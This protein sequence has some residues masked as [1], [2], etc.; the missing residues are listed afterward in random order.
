M[1]LA[2]PASIG[3]AG[4]I[5]AH[6]VWFGV[7]MAGGVSNLYWRPVAG[8]RAVSERPQL[9]P[10]RGLC[11]RS[12]ALVDEVAVGSLGQAHRQPGKRVEGGS[13]VPPP[14]PAEDEFVE[15][16]L[17]VGFAQA[18]EGAQTPALQVGEHPVHP[19]QQDM[20]GHAADHLA[21]VLVFLEAEIGRQ[22]VADDRGAG[23]DDTTD[24]PGDAGRREVVQAVEPDAPRLALVRQLDRADH[25]QLANVAAALA[26]GRRICLGPVGEV[27]LVHLD[28]IDQRGAIGV[29]HGAAQLM[30]QQPG[31]L[32]AAQPELG[33]KLQ[34]RDPVRMAAE[35]MDC[36][37]PQGQRQ[38]AA[39][40]RC[41]GR[42]RGLPAAPG[43]F[44]GEPLGGQLPA[45]CP[46]AG[47]A[48]KALR[49]ALLEQVASAGRIIGKSLRQLGT[50]HRTVMFPAA[51]H[52]NII[53]TSAPSRQ[54][55]LSAL[56]TTP[57]STGTKGISHKIIVERRDLLSF[58]PDSD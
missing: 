17:Q 1:V 40:H 15:I 56:D 8:G 4:R 54:L 27:A 35:E 33:L 51:R 49:P 50:R 36:G 13:G 10:G 44:P 11:G 32:V 53:G 47:R 19:G 30:Q 45:L 52:A 29:D 39:V 28:Q 25:Q 18:V 22:P 12:D 46:A 57:G 6:G 16:A 43:A 20:G 58:L 24:E 2:W 7:A 9:S 3:R 34:G 48:D 41:S 23:R 14:V 26:T 21:T 55:S 42:H 31:S 38:L 5:G 37:E